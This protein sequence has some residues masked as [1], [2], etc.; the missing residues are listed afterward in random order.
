MGIL[1]EE[2]VKHPK[3]FTLL[4]QW[5]AALVSFSALSTV[6]GYHQDEPLK[7]AMVMI[8]VY[9]VLLT[10]L[11]TM[12]G[13]GKMPV[14]LKPAALEV[15]LSAVI[16]ILLLAAFISIASH[17]HGQTNAKVSAGFAFLLWI[18]NLLST[19]VT[20]DNMTTEEEIDHGPS[21]RTVLD[22]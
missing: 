8:S 21:S 10:F 20:Y 9:W 16:N 17:T 19:Y 13:I 3:F 5:L 18:L 11:L 14:Y 15:G 2:N 6:S 12:M 1:E 22:I 7:F 4:G